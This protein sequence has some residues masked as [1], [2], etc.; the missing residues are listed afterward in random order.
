MNNQEIQVA[1]KETVVN[2]K[3]HPMKVENKKVTIGDTTDQI[4]SKLITGVVP[5][6]R[7]NVSDMTAGEIRESVNYDTAPLHYKGKTIQVFDVLDEFLSGE[8]V[9]GFHAGNVIKYVLRYRGKDGKND[10]LKARV[11]L[12]KLIEATL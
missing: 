1:I 12:D 3:E 7:K 4:L 10:L 11:Y 9:S 5:P 6:A 2:K 8:A